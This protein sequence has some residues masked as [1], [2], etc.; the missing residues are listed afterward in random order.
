MATRTTLAAFESPNL[1]MAYRQERLIGVPLRWLLLALGAV[2]VLTADF[3]PFGGGLSL[4]WF[5]YALVALLF[6]VLTWIADIRPAAWLLWF[7]FS[8]DAAFVSYLIT[9]SG[10]VVSPIYLLYGLLALKAV[11]LAPAIRQEIAWLPFALGPLYILVLWYYHG[12]LGFLREQ[13]FL[14]RY[15]L[16]WGWILAGSLA[17]WYVA[18]WQHRAHS[19]NDALARQESDLAQK[20]SVLQRTATDLGK[21]VLELR[22]LQEV[23]RS[24]TSTLRMEEVLQVIVGRL[25]N[26]LGASHC[27]VAVLDQ[28]SHRLM[29]SITTD[30]GLALAEQFEIVLSDEPATA[31]ALTSEQPVMVAD[32]AASRAV[33]QQALFGRWGMR[34]CLVI[35]LLARQRPIGALYLGDSRAHV[36]FGEPE[37]QLGLSFA[38]FA[39]TAIENAQLYQ[40]AWEKSSELEA[41]VVGIGDG[42]LVTD[43]HLCLLLM[44]PVAMR[45]FGVPHLATGVPLSSLVA[46]SPLLSVIEET[47]SST[48][49]P[50][51]REIEL[52]TARDGR[53]HTYQA[54]ASPMSSVDG[55]R[56]GVVTVLRDITAR[57]ELER[58]KTNF[59][60]VVSH[61]LKTPLHSIKGF[62]EIILMGKTGPVNDLQRDFLGTVKEQTNQLQRLISD[63]LEFSRMEA[64]Q[65]KLRMEQ[66]DL[67]DLVADVATKLGPQAANGGVNIINQVAPSFATIEA[68]PMRVEQVVTNLVDN[69][70]KF[71]PPGGAIRVHGDEEADAIVLRISDSGIGIPPEE[72]QR[73]FDRFYQVD[74]GSNR[75]YKGT[76][77]GLSICKHIVEHHGGR[78]WVESPGV[79]GQGAT[80]CFRLPRRHTGREAV[81]DFTH[82]PEPGAEPQT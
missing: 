47:L 16:L 58:M 25:A 82:L 21:R 29:G 80:F 57:V 35:P 48:Q 41:V 72:Q 17:T 11:L 73:I 2:I 64:G 13:G 3:S 62:V 51:V 81:L 10:G 71:T 49:Q 26:L 68:D 77:L 40:E 15:G 56:R 34:S 52:I 20:T 23:M 76:G 59:L 50:I 55:A 54:L 66:V 4:A 1:I 46:H 37:R 36:N 27:A 8:A 14:I 61:E 60:S 30:G 65:I 19:L 74:G 38:Y 79:N 45:I 53:A 75:L 31:E 18:Q 69:A 63:L 28:E 43:P 12:N 42:V 7:G 39:A 9:I 5:L 70:I 78:I 32:A 24:L 33:G 22:T 6:T 67:G 44:N